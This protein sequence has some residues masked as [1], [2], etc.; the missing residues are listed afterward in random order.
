MLLT[1]SNKDKA[2]AVQSIA[3]LPGPFS[4]TTAHNLSTDTRTRI[5]LLA[6]NMETTAGENVSPPTVQVEDAQRRVIS[7]PVEFVGKVPGFGWLTQI[8]VRL[9]NELA[10]AGEVQVNLTF[11]GR[12]S[13]R[14]VI[15]IA[16]PTRLP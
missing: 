4:I 15:T 13:N 6:R 3:F 5:T 9:P 2:I 14:A 12:T 7:L 10:V 8:V 1:E 16:T 11:R